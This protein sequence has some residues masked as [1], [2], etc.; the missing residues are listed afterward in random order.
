MNLKP[1]PVT[2]V[3]TEEANAALLKASRKMVFEEDGMVNVAQQE[4][5]EVLFGLLEK[6]QVLAETLAKC[7]DENAA[8][9]GEEIH[10]TTEEYDLMELSKASETEGPYIP[11]YG[12]GESS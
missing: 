1:G 6:C 3:T 12:R 10:K 9:L 7:G 11:D 5:K 2:L 4:L 8:W